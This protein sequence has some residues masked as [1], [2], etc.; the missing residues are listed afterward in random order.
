MTRRT[1]KLRLYRVQYGV[2]HLVTDDVGAFARKHRPRRC[3][4]M[5]EVKR[6]PVVI[7]VQ[8]DTFVEQHRETRSHLP[9]A[10]RQ[11]WRPEIRTPAQRLRSRPVSEAC[12]TGLTAGCRRLRGEPVCQ[13]LFRRVGEWPAYLDARFRIV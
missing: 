7:G 1:P 8:V 13:R 10:R 3:G 12:R 4:A 9:I 2:A 6:P 11:Q 5:K